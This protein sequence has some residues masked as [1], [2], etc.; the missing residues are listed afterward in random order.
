VIDPES[1]V[2]AEEGWTEGIWD[3]ITGLP[4]GESI[5]G[6]AGTETTGADVGEVA[7]V[8]HVVVVSPLSILMLSK[9]AFAW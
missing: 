5:D 2:G 9:S 4:E 1:V 7:E 6:R 3:G 8:T